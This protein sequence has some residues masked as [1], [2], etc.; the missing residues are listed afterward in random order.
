MSPAYFSV[1]TVVSLRTLRSL[2]HTHSVAD[3]PLLKGCNKPLSCSFNNV[4]YISINP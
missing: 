4:V 1:A 2:G 3:C